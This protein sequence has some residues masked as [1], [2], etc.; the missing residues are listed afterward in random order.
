M[1][2]PRKKKLRLPERKIMLLHGTEEM[3]RSAV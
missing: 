3:K 2:A 1:T